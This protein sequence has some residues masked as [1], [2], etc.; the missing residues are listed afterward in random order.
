MILS[1]TGAALAPLYRRICGRKIYGLIRMFAKRTVPVCIWTPRKPE[2]ASSLF[3]VRGI[4]PPDRPRDK[5]R[6]LKI[7]QVERQ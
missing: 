7:E 5:G 4:F 1:G 3:F 6:K 2:S